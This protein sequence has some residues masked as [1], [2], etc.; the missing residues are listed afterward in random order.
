MDKPLDTPSA[1][2]EA[3]L[4]PSPDT[5]SVLAQARACRSAPG[6]WDEMRASNPAA[7]AA[8]A[9]QSIAASASPTGAWGQF[10]NQI[11]SLTRTDLDAQAASLQRQIRD[12]GVT[13]NVYA[14]S[15]G[16]QRPWSLD[17]FPLIVEPQEWQKLASGVQQRVRLLEHVMQDVYG[18]QQLLHEGLLPAA[19]VHGHP[20]YLHTMAGVEPVG[21]VRLHV[22]ALDLARGPDGHWWV[23]TQRCQ[24]PSGL[25]YLLENRLAISRQ[26][27]QAFAA[28]KVQRLAGTYTALLES[29]KAHSPA[30]SDAHIALLTPGPYNETYF[31]HAYLARYLGISLVEGHDLLVRDE[32]VFLKTLRGLVPV[33]GLLKRVDDDFLDPL[34]L[35]ADSTLGV[36]GL[37][38]AIRAG[39]VLVANMPGSGFLESPALLGF[40]PKL[41][42]HVLGQALELPSLPTWWCGER[43]AM[44]EVLPRLAEMSIK[45]T[46][47]AGAQHSSWDAVLGPHTSQSQLDTWAG[48]IM[49]QPEEHTAQAFAPLSQMPIWLPGNASQQG[50]MTTRSVLLRVFA[51]SN[52]LDAQGHPQWR[53]LPGGL[54]RLADPQDHT[55]AMQRGGSSADVWALTDGELDYSSRFPQPNSLLHTQKRDVITSRAAEN[56]FWLGRYTER[57]ENSAQLARITLETLNSEHQTNPTLLQWLSELAE[58]NTLVPVGTPSAHLAKRVFERSVV[59][60]LGSNDVT[61]VGFNVRALRQAAANVRQRLS[62][63]HWNTIVR[64]EQQFSGQCAELLRQGDFSTHQALRTLRQLCDELAAVTGG[65]TDRMTRDDGWRLLSIGRHLERLAFLAHVLDTGMQSGALQSEGGFDTLLRL[66]DNLITFHSQYQQRRHMGALLD[67]LLLDTDNPRS[68]AWVAKTLRSRLAK[69]SDSDSTD[70][71]L[72]AQR[73]NNPRQWEQLLQ[74]HEQPTLPQL[75]S[76]QQELTQ[77]LQTL[78][79]SAYTLSDDISATYFTHIGLDNQSLSS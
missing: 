51:V 69:L 71:C 60:H 55:A 76:L 49:R 20:G 63:E 16:P 27:P 45:P 17:L 9:T 78:I 79:Q 75:P 8:S 18:P 53:V 37:L 66:F 3:A 19:L 28:L 32:K 35:R 65:Q 40:L 13:Y 62:P 33:H 30:G 24:A 54:A 43:S 77:L 7:S 36:P 70:E 68:L 1:A 4:W 29:L 57:A 46:Y 21:G 11:E 12:N 2:Q 56:L 59:A 41:A 73:I 58:Y 44:D 72:L 22:M 61:G 47:P 15:K 14:D 48:R 64:M 34:E 52:G 26:F 10:F 42:E 67:L 31:E 25:G 6:R 38:Q 23:V 39:N 50:R 5:D 74:L